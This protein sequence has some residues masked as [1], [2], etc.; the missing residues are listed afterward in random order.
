VSALSAPIL[1]RRFQLWATGNLSERPPSGERVYA[2]GEDEDRS[3][4]KDLDQWLRA[5]A[6][7]ASIVFLRPTTWHIN[8]REHNRVAERGPDVLR[9]LFATVGLLQDPEV[10]LLDT[11]GRI[12][13]HQQDRQA[14]AECARPSSELEPVDA[15]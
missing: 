10:A 3:E 14:R 13:R 15:A 6:V 5:D 11:A 2:I 7:S 12:A 8:L 9:Q 1:M 4:G